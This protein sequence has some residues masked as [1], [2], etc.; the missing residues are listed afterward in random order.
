MP[1]SQVSLQPKQGP[2]QD[3][4]AARARQ[5]ASRLR[6]P[7]EVTAR[8]AGVRPPRVRLPQR[9]AGWLPWRPPAGL[10]AWSRALGRWLAA[11]RAW[12]RPL[13]GR[14]RGAWEALA[15][16]CG[17]LVARLPSLRLP[18]LR[19]PAFLARRALPPP[20]QLATPYRTPPR[21]HALGRSGP[22][23]L[24]IEP[25]PPLPRGRA[26][27]RF[28]A[29]RVAT[30]VV[31]VVG[32]TAVGSAMALPM[33]IPAGAKVRDT[34]HRLGDVP[35]LARTLPRPPERSVVYASDG[36]RLLDVLVLDENR[37]LAKLRQVPLHVR[38]AVIAIEDIRFYEHDGV[39]YQGIARAAI[40]NL[41]AR[42]FS[43]GGSTITQQ[44]VKN[45]TNDKSKTIERKVREAIY[46]IE[47]E[48][49][50][51]KD[52][53][54]ERYLNEAYFG[55][56]YG[57]ATAAEYY[58]KK[59]VSKLTL[60]EAA[61]LAGTIRSPERYNPANEE[62]NRVRRAL[63]LDRM[64][65]AGFITPQQAAE[66][67]AERLRVYRYRP[68]EQKKHFTR[69]VEQQLLHDERF[70][71]ALGEPGSP[72]RKRLIYQG[73]LRI[74]TS[75]D[76]RLQQ[77]AEQAVREQLLA[78]Y[79]EGGGEYPRAALASVDPRTGQV[80][81]LAGGSDE[82]FD[83]QQVFYPVFGQGSM[84]FQP[85]SAFKTFFLVA[86]LEKGLPV[87]TALN[88]PSAYT[89]PFPECPGEGNKP[90]TVHNA[91]DTLGSGRLNMYQ[92]TQGS[93]NTYFVQLERMVGE[94]AAVDAARRMGITNA[95]EP[96]D[97]DYGSWVGTCTLTLGVKEVAPL[98]MAVAYGVLANQGKRC[99]PYV[100][101]RITGPDG[102]VLYEHK[103]SCKQVIDPGVANQ[104]VDMLRY[105]VTSGTGR[106]AQI[107]RPVFGKTG[108]A[109]HNWSAFFAGATPQL[110]TAVWVGDGE[111]LV[112]LQHHFH[113]G[114]VYGGTFPAGIF[115]QY[116]RGAHE[117]L[118]VM[119]F[120]KPPRGR[121]AAARQDRVP[122]VVG[123]QEEQAIRLLT[124]A[125]FRVIIYRGQGPQGI[126]VAQQPG[127]G[128]EARSRT[129]TIV[130]G[131]SGPQPPRPRP[132]PGPQPSPVTTVPEPPE[133]EAPA[134]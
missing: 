103:P 71:K 30:F 51:T 56:V 40:A 118:P 99:E 7:P 114:P 96:G 44:Y 134:P 5:L 108:S 117:G 87:T 68:E 60:A 91:G 20:G 16:A 112:P 34:A 119:G 35:P 11:A 14:L 94:E 54:L 52:Q 126:V 82:R 21:S 47:L 64:V 83:E 125:G 61:A 1:D 43:Q 79:P 85:G 33:L 38:Q 105:V 65:E 106:R 88:S 36:K 29:A 57:I 102:K 32:L 53:I 84:G 15:A 131:A 133:P 8:L 75:L 4:L 67:K 19:R 10:A 122:G 59:P 97:P 58:F 39:D 100:V 17:R 3:G 48:K 12:L 127:A 123:M 92:A 107:G 73:G 124:R 89:L 45:I 42:D 121:P 132:G 104:V 98:D 62:A 115:G 24:A 113:G 72:E 116:M 27:V 86:A 28:I 81:A 13:P 69:Y 9:G 23:G 6:L 50:L 130:V 49:R 70:T 26:L 90:H 95:P 128:A 78:G 63:V 76:L 110:A 129:V 46:A 25:L 111:E 80:V 109:Q 2:D 120:P 101:S 93:V 37:K 18:P 41:R 74:T 31:A 55:Q 77:L 22:G 66:A